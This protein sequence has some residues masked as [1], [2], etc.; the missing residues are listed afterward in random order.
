MI[1]LNSF[2]PAIDIVGAV[3]G[4][5][6]LGFTIYVMSIAK[7]ARQAA[8][9]AREAVLSNVRKRSLVEDLENIRRMVG[10]VGSLIQRE[11]WTAVHMRTEEI[12]GACK[13]TIARWGD[14]LD[15]DAKDG[16]GTASALLQSIASKSSEYGERELTLPEKN[17]LTS[18]HLRASGLLHTALGEARRLEERNAENDAN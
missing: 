11:E 8:E 7:D 17:K 1:D 10:Q 12:V 2:M 14:G 16:V 4:V 13:V 9:D 18:V 5:V 15:E 6:G 3:A